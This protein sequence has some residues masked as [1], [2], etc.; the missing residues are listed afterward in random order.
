M[1]YIDFR[2]LN[3]ACP[4]DDFPI[5]HIKLLI[6]GTT[7]YEAFS[8]IDGCSGYSQIKMHPED[9]EIRHSDHLMVYSAIR[10]CH[11]V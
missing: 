11:S 7:G 3:K 1:V 5:P 10:L 4:K 8:F 9:V 2:D 6:D